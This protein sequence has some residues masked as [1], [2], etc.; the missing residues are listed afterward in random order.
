MDN[1]F[2]RGGTRRKT[3]LRAASKFKAGLKNKNQAIAH[4]VNDIS[5]SSASAGAYEAVAV[6]AAGAV[7]KK[8]SLEQEQS[9]V[10]LS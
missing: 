7:D 5:G 6:T 2:A 9:D 8:D 3:V 1:I 4:H 10:V